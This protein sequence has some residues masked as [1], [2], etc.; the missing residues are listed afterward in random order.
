MN[1]DEALEYINSIPW[2]SR[3]VG[4][5][6]INEL[7][8]TLGRPDENLK[9]IHVAGTNGKGSVCAMLASVFKEAG[10]KTGLFTSPHLV[11]YNE[12]IRID[13]EDIPD[14]GLAEVITL[15]AESAKACSEEPSEFEILTAAGLL[16]F[17]K[18][19][20]DI[21]ILEVGLGGEFDSTNAIRHKELAVITP[22]GFDHMAILGNTLSRIAE[23]KAG[24]IKNT[25]DAVIA[26]QCGYC[27]Q[28]GMIS[29]TGRE[30]DDNALMEVFKEKCLKEGA[31]MH[32][33]DIQGFKVIS[34]NV[35]GEC[36]KSAYFRRELELSLIGDYQ[37]MN[38]LTVL[39]VIKVLKKDGWKISA[40]A[41]RS[42]LKKAAW[43]ARFEVLH[44]N[45][46]FILDGAHNGHGISA[47][48]D[49][50]KSLFPGNRIV[51]ILGMLND[52]DTD[53]MLEK[54]YTNADRFIIL[55]PGSQRALT[56]DILAER[57]KK[58]GFEAVCFKTPRDA[59]SYAFDTVG[60]GEVI[61]SLGSLY[62]AGSVRACFISK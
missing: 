57:I 12:R 1:Y 30:D 3:K 36:F 11:K 58:D 34:E 51:Y 25:G 45:P 41:V 40:Q 7:L 47:A 49:S 2:T 19:N 32:V 54:L 42:G 48:V 52:K 29:K 26:L 5:H 10:F 17:A 15:V 31:E 50:L 56:G 55:T 33:P 61:C 59:V 43:P 22:I 28:N 4:L 8:N 24:I 21:V 39:E 16:W 23:A 62:L 60:S 6:R 13:G 46:V 27:I 37:L 38:A 9:F 53:I 18:N 20:C 35:E 44:N 14:Q